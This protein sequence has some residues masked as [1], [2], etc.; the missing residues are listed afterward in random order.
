MFY[1]YM[2]TNKPNG[3]L[4]IGQTDD[5]SKRAF[6]HKTKVY[7]GFSRKYGCTKL[8]WFERHETRA[9]A[10]LRETRMKEW[11]RSWKIRRIMKLNPDWNDLS[12]EWTETDVFD[13]RRLFDPAVL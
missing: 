8:V 5:L 11:K 13:K 9:S 4:Y 1:V 2:V 6:E 12:E 3:T 10:V 7:P